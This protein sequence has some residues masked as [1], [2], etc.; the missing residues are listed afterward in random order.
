MSYDCFRKNQMYMYSIEYLAQI[1][2][3]REVRLIVE[4]LYMYIA[5]F[6]ITGLMN[7]AGCTL[8]RL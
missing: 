8:S 4:F 2:T 1:K 6:F 5:I 3:S 7:S